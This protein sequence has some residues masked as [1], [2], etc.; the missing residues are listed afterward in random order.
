MQN[1]DSGNL[2]RCP[3]VSDDPDILKESSMLLYAAICETFFN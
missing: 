2:T 1:K 3:P